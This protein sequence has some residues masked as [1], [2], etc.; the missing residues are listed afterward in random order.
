MQHHHRVAARPI[1]QQLRV[2]A[3]FGIDGAVP[4]AL[5]QL[6]AGGV[7]DR[8]HHRHHRVAAA[9]SRQGDRLGA[10]AVENYP[11]PEIRQLV[12]ADLPVFGLLVDAGDVE[13]HRDDGVATVD[14]LQVAHLRTGSAEGHAVPL[15]RQLILADGLLHG[16]MVGAQDVEH[17][18]DDRVAAV[19]GLQRDRL[20]AGVVERHPVPRERERVGADGGVPQHR[21]VLEYREVHRHHGI[22]TRRVGECPR[23]VAGGGVGHPTPLVFVAGRL[24]ECGGVRTADGQMQRHHGIATRRVGECPRVVAGGGVGHPTPLVFVAG[25]LGECCS[26]RTADGQ[27]QCHHGIATRRIGERPRVVAGF[28]ECLAVP[29]IFVAGCLGECGGIRS[30]DGQVQC[31]HGVAAR[32][33]RER[34][35]VVASGGESLAIPNVLVAGRLGEC[36]GIRGVDG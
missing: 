18:R 6:R 10:R 26:V 31:H 2:G 21:G 15:I 11:V 28:G 16:R 13:H 14:R 32:R 25:R 12:D 5:V 20:C 30:V 23:V 3:R 22:A 35:C 1:G 33:V 9:D 29:D 17:H 34:P 7:G 4:G 36:G 19:D 24:G 27:V 8:E